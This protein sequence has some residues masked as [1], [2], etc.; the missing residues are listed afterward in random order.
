MSVEFHQGVGLQLEAGKEIMRN[1]ETV[2]EAVDALIIFF[3]ASR[4]M[5]LGFPIFPI[6]D[7]IRYK[8]I[9]QR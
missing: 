9:L 3:P 1:F 4:S 7:P 2:V 6:N 5:H 8:Y